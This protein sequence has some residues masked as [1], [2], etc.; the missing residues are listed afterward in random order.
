MITSCSS[1]V[2][3]KAASAGRSIPGMVRRASL[4]IAM[5]APV[6]PA[7]TAAPARP[8]FTALTASPIDVVLARRSARLGS[9]S[10]P[11]T[12]SQCRISDA[13]RMLG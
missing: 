10:P 9:S 11:T 12:S 13:P 3:S 8:S 7:L 6:F 4:L 5:R 2:G 1:S